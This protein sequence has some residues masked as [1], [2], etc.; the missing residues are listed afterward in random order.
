MFADDI[1]EIGGDHAV[2]A[3]NV[4]S[5]IASGE[6]EPDFSSEGDARAICNPPHNMLHSA[7]FQIVDN[8]AKPAKSE[9]GKQNH[10]H[11]LAK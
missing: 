4:G 7:S 2:D 11:V 8:I 10:L 5:V 3:E 9:A 1:G 6:R